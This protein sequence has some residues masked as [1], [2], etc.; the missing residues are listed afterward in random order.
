MTYLGI[1]LKTIS[2]NLGH[3]LQIRQKCVCGCPRTK[4]L[5]APQIPSLKVEEATSRQREERKREKENERREM[6]GRNE[7]KLPKI[8]FCNGL[9]P[10]SQSKISNVIEFDALPNLSE[11]PI[12]IMAFKNQNPKNVDI[13]KRIK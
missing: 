1:N 3:K 10:T 8:M 11:A 7:R 13:R 9:A 4:W 5:I 2:V 12:E 6:I